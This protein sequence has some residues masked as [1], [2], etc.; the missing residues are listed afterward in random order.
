MDDQTKQAITRKIEENSRTVYDPEIRWISMSWA[1]IQIV[2]KIPG[3]CPS[4][5]TLTSPGMSGSGVAP[6]EV[7]TKVNG[8]EGVTALGRYCLGSAMES[9]MM[10]GT[11]KTELGMYLE[12]RYSE[13]KIENCECRI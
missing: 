6:P 4:E 9:D 5:L 3:L 7:E 11:G 12:F 8:I 2:S 10:S 13:E 1:G